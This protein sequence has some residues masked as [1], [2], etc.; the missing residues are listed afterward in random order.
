[1][2]ISLEITKLI[3]DTLKKINQSIKPVPVR[4]SYGCRAV[5]APEGVFRQGIIKLYYYE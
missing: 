3:K 2:D 5:G 4:H 1:M